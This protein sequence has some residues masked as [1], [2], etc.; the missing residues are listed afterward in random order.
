[1]IRRESLKLRLEIPEDFKADK[2]YEIDEAEAIEFNKCF[3]KRKRNLLCQVSI[4]L[5]NQ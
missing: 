5:G 2:I 4:D 3:Q 1:M